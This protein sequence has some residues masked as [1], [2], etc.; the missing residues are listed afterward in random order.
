MD[1]QAAV[2]QQ[3][4]EVPLNLNLQELCQDHPQMS[5]RVFLEKM[6]IY[7]QQLK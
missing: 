1:I 6:L 5:L 7:K 4:F 3:T 2:A